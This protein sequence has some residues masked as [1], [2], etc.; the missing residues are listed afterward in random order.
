M[1]SKVGTIFRE[2]HDLALKEQVETV[3]SAVEYIYDEY[4]SGKYTED[5][6]KEKAAN[7]VRE[8]RYGVGGYFWIDDFDGN[9]IVILGNK[10]IEGTNRYDAIDMK[11]F[12]LIKDFIEKGRNGGGFTDY[13][14]TKEGKG[15]TPYHMRAY[16]KAFDE[17]EWVIGTGDYTDDI[18]LEI[19]KQQN[20]MREKMNKQ[21][22]FVGIIIVVILIVSIISAIY[23]SKDITNNIDVI[24]NSLN[25]LA[26]GNLKIELPKKYISRKDEFGELVNTLDSMK[27]S[28]ASLIL[29]SKDISINNGNT[30]SN[31]G[32]EMK[33]IYENIE[34][35]SAVTEELASGME[36]C[37]ASSQEMAAISHELDSA[38]KVI[39]NKSNEGL[40]EAIKIAD[41]ATKT[42][43]N[44][45]KAGK[46]TENVHNKIS[47]KMNEALENVKVVDK[48]KVLS[49]SILAITEQTNLLALNAAIEA[50]RAGESGKG[51]AV[52]ADEIRELAVASKDAAQ[53]II[54]VTLEVQDSVNSLVDNCNEVLLFMKKDIREDYNG[55][56][57]T[58][59]QYQKD[60]QFVYELVKEFEEKA[61]DLSRGIESVLNAVDEVAR[62]TEEGAQGTTEISQRTL[63]IYDKSEKILSGIQKCGEEAIELEKEIN[64]FEV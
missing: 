56:I 20:A 39:A 38:S 4:K 10:E 17:F 24:K 52:V 30:L 8:L 57:N 48:I 55:F 15:D 28:I 42:R 31:I 49:D 37:A 61:T 51:F 1:F 14:L 9:N 41:R 27:D 54:N 33:A 53:N 43:E 18:E 7:M 21:N 32:S 60:A 36:E 34:S 16:S 46:H 25:T 12:P 22:L 11:E 63:D 35:V 19:D 47:D 6:A 45:E 62:A 13:Y 5:E 59:I 3:I 58:S 2:N 29:K 50:A 26:L 44:T 64:K 23:F 40:K